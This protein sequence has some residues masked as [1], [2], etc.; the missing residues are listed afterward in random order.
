MTFE[1]FIN[2][3]GNCR[4]AVEFYA[5]VFRTELRPMMTFGDSPADPNNPYPENERNW[6]MYTDL[7]IG[8]KLI[9]FMDMTS[10]YPFVAG[11]NITPTIN[12]TDKAEVDRLFNEL[13]EGGIVF[14]PPQKTFFSEYYA[15]LTDKFGIIW[16][17]LLP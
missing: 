14:M 16:H 8:D 5:K 17:I 6:I 2:F 1:L 15:M 10:S 3:N 4:E 11:N 9:M 7:Q 12:V 13:S